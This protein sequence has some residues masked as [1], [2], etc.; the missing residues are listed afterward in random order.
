MRHFH[1][2]RIRLCS[3]HGQPGRDVV[4]SRADGELGVAGLPLGKKR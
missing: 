2:Y 3:G 4:V 1:A